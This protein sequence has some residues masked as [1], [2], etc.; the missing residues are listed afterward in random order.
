MEEKRT[1]TP[2]PGPRRAAVSGSN[3]V[4][5]RKLAEEAAAARMEAETAKLEET[6]PDEPEEEDITQTE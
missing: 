3:R 5:R 6:L 4:L 1:L 2:E